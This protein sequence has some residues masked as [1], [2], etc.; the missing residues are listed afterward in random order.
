[1]K[2]KKGRPR[3]A[4]YKKCI[5]CGEKY[6]CIQSR[7]K[8]AKFCSH[9]CAM[10]GKNNHKYRGGS[11]SWNGYKLIMINGKQVRE[12]RHLMELHIGRKLKINEDI[13]HKNGD[14][15]DNRI[16]NLKILTRK[17]HA[18]ISYQDRKISSNGQFL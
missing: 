17:K 10:L 8:I 13:H 7:I 14:K 9:K 16:K 15:L 3:K 5:E 1:M 6:Y 12:H 11:I 4:I 2:N 18:K